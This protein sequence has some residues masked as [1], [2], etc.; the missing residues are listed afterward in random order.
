MTALDRESPHRGYWP[1]RWPVECGGNRRQKS[2]TGRLDA[3]EGSAHV[4]TSTNDR[5]NVM[6]IEREPGE[7]FLGGTMAAFSG[8]APFGWVQ[9]IDAEP[10]GEPAGGI[11]APPVNPPEHEMAVAWDSLNGGLAGIDTSGDGLDVA[12]HLD[13]RPTMQPVVFPES[14]ELVINDFT[15]DGDDELIVVDVASGEL[16]DRVATG[17]RIANGMFL[18][19]GG[20]RDIFYCTTTTVARISWS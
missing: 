10:F 20:D 3:A 2:A 5:W 14:G 19:P 9:R 1:S 15:R 18:T 7:W 12:W 6:V 16:L 8:P 17:S 11:I 13:V 4:V